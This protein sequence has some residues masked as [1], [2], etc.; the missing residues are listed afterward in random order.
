MTPTLN[1]IRQPNYQVHAAVTV[2]LASIKALFKETK[3]DP[4]LTAY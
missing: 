3:F 4:V 2:G 1:S